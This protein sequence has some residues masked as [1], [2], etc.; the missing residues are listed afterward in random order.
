MHLLC[1]WLVQAHPKY[2]AQPWYWSR[3]VVSTV[4]LCQISCHFRVDHNCIQVYL[5]LFWQQQS[6]FQQSY[7][8]SSKPWT[9]NQTLLKMWNHLHSVSLQ[10][11]VSP[12]TLSYVTQKLEHA[13]WNDHFVWQHVNQVDRL[14]IIWRDC[15]YCHT[16][17]QCGMILS[18]TYTMW[19]DHK[20]I[21]N[22]T[23]W[24]GSTWKHRMLN[25]KQELITDNVINSCL[26]SPLWNHMA[27]CTWKQLLVE[28]ITVSQY[29]QG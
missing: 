27:H 6:Q 26:K 7:A 10:R 8:T 22:F 1:A 19:S 3:L 2:H 4:I 18:H 24:G 28:S 13:T 29:L 23:C 25:T 9:P 14:L 20:K 17:I 5:S 21:P 12:L 11:W 16:H 15:V